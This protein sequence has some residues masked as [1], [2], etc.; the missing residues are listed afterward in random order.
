MYGLFIINKKAVPKIIGFIFAD[1]ISFNFIKK[2]NG[3]DNFSRLAN[4]FNPQNTDVIQSPNKTIG[5][6]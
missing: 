4:A 6:F 1:I 3:E 2:K 5:C